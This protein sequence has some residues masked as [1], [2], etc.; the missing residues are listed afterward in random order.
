MQAE[1]RTHPGLVRDNNEDSCLIDLERGLFAVADGMGGHQGGEVASRLA[2]E[3]VQQTAPPSP[4][5]SSTADLA[6]AVRQANQAV[7]TTAQSNNVLRG[8]GTTITVSL[9][10]EA[11]LKLANVGDSR[12]YLI[13]QGELILLTT[14]HSYVGELVRNGGLTEDEAMDHPQRNLLTRALGTRSE[15]QIDVFTYSWEP[16]DYLLLCTDGLYSMV[17]AAEIIQFVT[18]MPVAVAV[19]QLINTAIQR[20]GYDNLSVVLVYHD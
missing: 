19:E 17:T 14:D 9:A 7:Y 2:L 16:G 4:A 10:D 13:H 6:A 3:V 11:E 18:A 20:G 15:V 12:A 8:M 1:A 5:S